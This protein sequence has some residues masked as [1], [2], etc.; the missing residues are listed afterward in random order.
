MIAARHRAGQH[1]ALF[2]LGRSG[3]AAAL[4]LMAGG[5]RVTAW[6][7]HGA[8][9]K[10]A[11]EQNIPLMDLN[12]A[13]FTCFDALVLAPGVPLTHPKPHWVVEKA[14]A[15]GVP[16]IGDTELF[17]CEISDTKAKL[18]AITGT[19]GKSTTTALL[20]HILGSYLPCQSG[21][22]I[23]VPVL[24][25]EHFKDQGI[26]V[27]E[28]SS[29]QIDLTPSLKP[30]IAI[31][32]NLSPDHL[33]RHGN[34]DNYA[35]V[36][37][38]IFSRQSSSDTAIIGMDDS[39][40]RDMAQRIDE[41]DV[42]QISG[43]Q[44]TDGISVIDGSLCEGERTLL[45]LGI[46][47]P[48]LGRHNGQNIAAAFAAC[49]A[50]DLD[51]GDFVSALATFPGLAHRMEYVG[52][53][54]GCDVINDSKATNVEAAAMALSSLE[55]IHWILGGQAKEGGI[56]DLLHFHDKI[57]HA[58]LIGESENAFAS[59]LEGKIPYTKCGTMERAV[60]E[61]AEILRTSSAQGVVLLSPAAASFDQYPNFEIRGEDFKKHICAQSGFKPGSLEV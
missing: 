58:Y 24:E 25:L 10:R 45:A 61:I 21:G 37:E 7:D 19:N 9:R 43:Y 31:C 22:N 42:V 54:Y 60:S 11:T 59:T 34:M 38:K 41:P 33:E 56:E 30:D 47:K 23:G 20:G 46:I 12:E 55:N 4:A 1:L 53:L 5:A 39:Y 35:A 57:A 17:A 29:Y 28:F 49:Q 14:N 18:V 51:M 40:C 16:V 50:L 44:H 26:Y 15:S 36:K 48:L 6:D 52:T 2:G 32:L 13:D 27:I 8:S 3:L